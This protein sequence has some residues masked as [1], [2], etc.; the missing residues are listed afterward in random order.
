MS[1]LLDQM[2]QN[3][4]HPVRVGSVEIGGNDFVVV[5]G[6]CS[7][8]SREQ[9]LE[10]ARSVNA[11]G[12]TLLRGGI[13]KMRTQPSSFQG[14]GESAYPIALEVKRQTGMSLVSE[15]TDVRQMGAMGEVVDLFQVGARNMH[16]YELLKELGRF[17]KP[18]LVKRGFSALIEEWVAAAE[19]VRAAGNKNV[20][21]C[22]RGI[23][24][25]DH[26]LRN[27]LDLGAVAW[28][29]ANTDIPVIVDPSHGTGIRELIGPMCLASAAAGADGLLLEV[30]PNPKDAL[31]D[32]K[33]ALTLDDFSKIMRDLSR[34]LS[35]VGRKIH[36]AA[37]SSS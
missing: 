37:R 32:G 18:V 13:F 20:I 28:A 7:I 22:E 34:V 9:F 35:A 2:N 17:G 30:H 27:T 4:C 16:N 19:Y 36:P 10:T 5:A 25:F 1:T 21:L 15:I 33:Q 14:L 11:A 23:R 31:S 24:T 29:K 26:T 12:A 3:R 8:E 6:P